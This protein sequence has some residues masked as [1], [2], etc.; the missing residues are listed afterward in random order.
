MQGT[1]I[2]TPLHWPSPPDPDHPHPLHSPPAPAELAPV[3]RRTPGPAVILIRGLL[4]L[5][6]SSD[7]NLSEQFLLLS[8]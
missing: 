7:V 4:V 6:H 2:L 1:K 8:E 5:N 3:V